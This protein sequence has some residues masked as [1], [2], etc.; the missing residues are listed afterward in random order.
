MKAIGA[1]T[2][3][4]VSPSGNICY[5]CDPQLVNQLLE[6]GA[7]EKPAKLMN[8]LDIFGPTMT[9]TNNAQSKVYRRLTAPFF[10]EDAMR[11]VWAKGLEGAQAALGT[12]ATDN[13]SSFTPK[14]R[15][16]FASLSLYVINAECFENHQRVTAEMGD[17]GRPFAGPYDDLQ[18]SPTYDL[19]PYARTVPHWVDCLE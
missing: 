5:T 16:T 12:F 14:L 19:R 6:V 11:N 9:G 18:P 1:D 10:G 17:D 15:P 2:F 4:A 8:V 3:I 13:G 7:V